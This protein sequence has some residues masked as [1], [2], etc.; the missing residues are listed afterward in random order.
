M[1]SE[2]VIA[3]GGLGVFLIGMKTMTE[4]LRALAGAWLSRALARSTRSPARG[5]AL[6]A[7]LTALI[8]SSSATTVAA[9]GFVG[10]E[11]LSFPQALGIVFGA[12]LGTTFTGW[13]VATLGFKVNLGVAAHAI[14]LGGALLLLL[15]AGRTAAIGRTLAGFALLFLGLDA[16]KD[17]LSGMQALIAPERMPPDT[18]GGRA[19]L[20][21]TG[22]GVTMITQSSSAGV[23]TALAALHTGSLTLTQAAALVIGMDI[24]TSFT[25]VIASLG[26]SLPMRRT[27]VSNFLFNLLSALPGY[28][29]LPLFVAGIAGLPGARQ[30]E[31]ALVGFHSLYNL[32][33][34]LVAV[35]LARPF[36]RMIEFLVRER[37]RPSSQLDAS[38]ARDPG[39]AIPA[40][41]A[42]LLR[43]LRRTARV[44]AQM[45]L[46]PP[47]SAS[48][49]GARTALLR[50]DLELLRA[51]LGTVSTDD[52][53]AELHRRHL[54]LLHASDHIDRYLDRIEEAPAASA[55]QDE[56]ARAWTRSLATVVRDSE[57]GEP[58]DRL[59]EA[60]RAHE[61]F[62]EATSAS[63]TLTMRRS[64]EGALTP[65]AALGVLDELRRIERLALHLWRALLYLV[66]ARTAE[67]PEEA[68]P[69]R[70]DSSD[71]DSAPAAP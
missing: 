68:P 49:A 15:G 11:V 61:K 51:D 67:P 48:N 66:A 22:C 35:P 21:L 60:R 37:A 39:V 52:Q 13:I 42:A 43:L 54:A 71:A 1:R 28:V 10:A 62:L 12:N 65:V 57:R 27:G 38:V 47:A 33:G 23:A 25:A 29:L 19:L 64:A 3:A 46:D 26:G 50:A 55:L 40:C 5:A 9:V 14:A 36:A 20:V 32:F 69:A 4:G 41:A 34:V 18:W 56:D 17:A 53:S 7:G 44:T 58:E 30:P 2:I 16:L 70:C 59:P 31:L 6:G 24:G 8:Q 63:R 45:L